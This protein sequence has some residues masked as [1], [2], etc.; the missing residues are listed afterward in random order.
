MPV[1]PL[2]IQR[3]DVD[4]E[5]SVWLP[6]TPR[7]ASDEPQRA[8]AAPTWRVRP[9]GVM[10]G[11]VLAGAAL[12]RLGLTSDGVFAAG[13][14]AVLGVLAVID[15]EF[16]VLPNRILGPAAVA[17]LVLQAALFPDRLVECI[18]AGL[19]AALL[20]LLPTLF[21]RRAMGMGDVKL[22]GLLGLALGGKVLVALM[23]GSLASVP[24]ALVLVVRGSSMR[25][26]TL[27]FGPFLAF[28]AAV[29]L[30]V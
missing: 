13:L 11:A 9:A 21:Q 20:L 19:G 1:D 4:S 27:P 14:L 30:L 5:T 26:A 28:G 17:V 18:V 10:L 22:A 23:L 16:R 12:L 25:G 8:P 24:A 6:V 2:E 29:T 3:I 7:A 15:L